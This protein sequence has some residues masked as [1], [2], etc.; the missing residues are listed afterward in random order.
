MYK[1]RTVFLVFIII[2]ACFVTETTVLPAIAIMDIMPNLMII[3]TASYGFMFGDRSG[4]FIGF[5]C[6][7]LCDIY[8][9]PLIGFQAA[10]YALI[11][12]LTGKFRRILYVEDLAFPLFLIGVS[13]LI[14]GFITYVFLFLIQNRLFLRIFFLQC[15]VPE[16]VYTLAAA[17]PLYPLLRLIYDRFMRPQRRN[18]PDNNDTERKASNPLSRKDDKGGLHV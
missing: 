10:I 14:Y 7:L 1:L 15:M 8:F 5:V 2:I 17:V 18:L 16:L 6:G 12:Y 13:D 4:I 9:G 3:L 11:G